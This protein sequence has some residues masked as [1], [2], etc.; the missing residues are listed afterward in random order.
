MKRI[1]IYGIGGLYNFGCEAIVRGTVEYIHQVYG[2]DTNITFY[3]R[4]IDSDKMITDNLGISIVDIR[5]NKS[6]FT[7]SIS[8]IV[9]ILQIPITPFFTKEFNLI[10]S[11][12]DIVFSVGGDIYTISKY[13]RDRKKYRY[14]NYLV[15]FGRKALKSGKPII[16]YGASIGPF[17][18]YS[19]AVNYYINHLRKVNQIICREELSVDYLY[20]YGVN[21]NVQFLPDPAFLVTNKGNKSEREYI[22]VNFSELSLQELFGKVNEKIVIDI[23]NLLEVIAIDI[24]LPIMLIPHVM[25]PFTT[26]DNDFIFLKK[27][28]NNLSEKIKEK[29]VLVKPKNFI[30]TKSY[31]GKCKVVIAARMHC[32]VN[33]ITVGTPAIFLS[34]SQ[35]ARGMAKY[36]YGDDKWCIPL[37]HISEELQPALYSMLNDLEA[38]DNIVAKRN[39]EISI[40]YNEYFRLK[41]Y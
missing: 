39:N 7:K 26:E 34:Y 3:S 27:I 4:T 23:C 38:I 15:E 11:Q 30:D 40:I 14:V 31:L 22:G 19:K 37:Q 21:D 18:E 2:E 6:L 28:Y 35:K 1:A 36:V 9:D 29:T 33:S 8:K 12:S 24:K 5:R 17:G 25:S 10:L 16:I 20:H 32:A 41:K 13:H